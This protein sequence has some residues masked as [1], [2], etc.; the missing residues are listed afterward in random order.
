[1]KGCLEPACRSLARRRL[2]RRAS[3]ARRSRLSAAAHNPRC[4]IGGGPQRLVGGDILTTRCSAHAD[5]LH[6]APGAAHGC[7]PSAPNHENQAFSGRV[8]PAQPVLASRPPSG[9]D[10][11]HENRMVVRRDGPSARLYS[12]NAYDWRARLVAI[13]AA[14]E[15]IKATNFTIDGEAVVLD[16]TACHVR[17]DPHDAKSGGAWSRLVKNPSASSSPI[18]SWRYARC[19]VALWGANTHWP[20]RARILAPSIGSRR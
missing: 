4:I 14:A 12:R 18:P 20:P 16:L 2:A 6:A 9:A 10:W 8:H 3:K 15:L 7:R 19:A 17:P 13:A 11:V 5:H 1:M